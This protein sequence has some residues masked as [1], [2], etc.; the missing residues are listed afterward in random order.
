VKYRQSEGFENL[1]VFETVKSNPRKRSLLNMTQE[2]HYILLGGNN[3]VYSC[4]ACPGAYKNFTI[5]I[6]REGT[7]SGCVA[8]V[9]V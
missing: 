2:S 7:L 1:Y 4:L 8:K 9:Q 5:F 6:I 3:V